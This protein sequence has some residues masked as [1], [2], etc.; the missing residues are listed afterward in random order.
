[1]INMTLSLF[2]Y[3]DCHLDIGRGPSIKQHIL[4]F[5]T[6]SMY[7]IYMCSKYC[8]YMLLSLQPRGLCMLEAPTKV[9]SKHH[10]LN[11]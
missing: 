5:R 8:T 3:F 6:C 11:V 7:C 1:M 10:V 9:C 2:C 4:V